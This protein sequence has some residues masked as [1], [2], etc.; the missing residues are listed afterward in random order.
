M[1]A[2]VQNA[3]PIMN[4]ILSE[5]RNAFARVDGNHVVPVSVF[6]VA[7]GMAATIAGG[8]TDSILSTGLYP[9]NAENKAAV[10]GMLL[11]IGASF[12]A[13]ILANDVSIASGNL[14]VIPTMTIVKNIAI[15]AVKDVFIMVNIIPEAT[16]LS[17]G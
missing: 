5:G 8:K 12:T 14:C 1:A 17:C 15:L 16:P 7:L 4:D 10:G 11:R 2:I 9:R 6:R 3:A 13:P